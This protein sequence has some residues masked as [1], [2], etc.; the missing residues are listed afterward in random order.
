MCEW[1]VLLASNSRQVFL[2]HS[3][4]TTA[5]LKPR[6]LSRNWKN[7]NNGCFNKN[8][9][10]SIIHYA[11]YSLSMYSQMSFDSNIFFPVHR[12]KE[13]RERPA[14][15][16]VWTTHGAVGDVRVIWRSSFVYMCHCLLSSTPS[17]LLMCV[18]SLLVSFVA[19]PRVAQ[20]PR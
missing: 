1:R 4:P 5:F 18:F 3:L 9:H 13:R 6:R 16:V 19:A 12:Q 7:G 17:S 10:A 20:R 14:G 11:A 8:Y 2:T 15:I